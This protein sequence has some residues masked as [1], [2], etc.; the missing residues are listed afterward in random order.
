MQVKGS[1]FVITGGASGLGAAAAEM[2]VA[3][4]GKVVVA[5]VKEDEGKAFAARLGANARFV[6]CDV[7][8]EAA[9][10][11]AVKAAV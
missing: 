5:D 8:D 4:G 10:N 7:T 3:A 9:A 11:A 6:R 2:L 1:S